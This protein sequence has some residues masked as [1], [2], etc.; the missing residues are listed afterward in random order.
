MVCLQAFA[1]PAD[2][3]PITVT[4]PN[5]EE[6]TL[7]MKGDEFINWA[8]TLDGYT[9][10]INSE[11][12]FCYAQVNPSGNLEPSPFIATEIANRPPEVSAWLQN[13]NK[14]SFYSDNQVYFY[15]QLR[16]IYEIETERGGDRGTTGLNKIPVILMEFPDRPFRK[17][18]ED[19]NMLFNQIS[20]YENGF[21]GSFRDFYLESSYNK[22]DVQC[23]IFG[24]YMAPKEATHYAY[25]TSQEVNPY[26]ADFAK[27]AITAAYND[28]VDFSVFTTDGGKQIEGVYA[29]Y[30]GYDKSAGCSSCIWAHAQLSFSY[31]YKGFVFKRYAASSELQNTSGSNISTI[32]TFCHEYGH[33]LGALDYYDTNYGTGGQYD[34]TGDWDLQASGSHNDGGKKPATP[35]PR[36]KV[37]TY[38]WANAIVLDSP[39]RCTIPVSRIYDHAFFRINTPNSQEY[40]IIENKKKS[41][42][43]AGIPGENL[44]IYKCTENYETST[45]YRSNTTSWQ[46][47]YPVAANAKV[48]VPEAGSNKQSQY[49]NINSSTCTWPQKNQT[50][51]TNS[52]IPGMVTW[53][54]EPVNK[55][56]ENIQVFD[57]YIVFDFMGGGDKQEC[58]VFLPAYYGC[59]ITPEAGSVSPVNF[60]E[61]FSFK[62]DLL[63]SHDK[64]ILVVTA[65]N[66]T[67]VPVNNIYTI[68][69]IQKDIIVR[70][71]GVKFNSFAITVTAGENGKITPDGEVQVNEGK[72][73]TFNIQPDNGFSIDKVVVDGEDK[74]DIKSY[75][76]TNVCEPHTLEAFFKK[77]VLYTI[78]VSNEALTFETISN[79]PS[80]YQEVTI[81]SKD[82]IAGIE[83][84]APNR[85]KVSS[86]KG[87]NWTQ[88]FNV[89]K[90]KLP[91]TFWIRF[92]PP[93]GMGNVGTFHEVLALKSTEAYAEIK[94]TGVSGVGINEM[95]H[96]QNLVIYPNPTSGKLFIENGALNKENSLFVIEIYDVLGKKVFE[97][98]AENKKQLELDITPLSAGIYM[99]A[100]HTDKGIVHQKIVKE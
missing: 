46:R 100:V 52:S 88:G 2:S 95:D 24:P 8:E 49:G 22:L 7:I 66:D 40:F 67:L 59:K 27:D 81:S 71:K 35:N 33:V 85:F 28:G 21:K 53:E 47:F 43:D 68:S 79:V 72:T 11:F 62:I 60:N 36:S 83:V 99:V 77:G 30:A 51:F 82:V 20:Y 89:P 73:Q 92:Q 32:G 3:K 17:T 80:D 29:I 91:Y 50:D 57:D 78:S 96:N 63:P 65:N 94:L 38:K 34:G 48:K 76:F 15:M 98:K 75:T 97:E 16:E 10:L 5:G 26:Y 12:Y 74:G 6:I 23:S 42:F 69:Y 70:V 61:H 93:W 45:P 64:S 55:P 37:S 41:G 9:L 84:N 87:S 58:N 44:L 54:G 18:K 90:N 1:V 19:F 4:Q 39:Q 56:I 31:S 13:I 25:T 86:D 14:N